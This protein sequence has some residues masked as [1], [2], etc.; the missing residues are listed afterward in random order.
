MTFTK[1]QG[2]LAAARQVPLAKIILETDC[3]F[4]APPPHR[5]RRNEPAFLADTLA[6]LAALRQE[7][8]ADLAQAST[9]NAF[10]LFGR[11]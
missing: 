10:E 8:P 6:L 9:A 3:P 11:W 5:G 2:Q 4:L 1:D 7:K